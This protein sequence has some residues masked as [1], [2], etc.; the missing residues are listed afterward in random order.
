MES[1]EC[2]LID[3]LKD[4]SSALMPPFKMDGVQNEPYELDVPLQT[5]SYLHESAEKRNVCKKSHREEWPAKR[6]LTEIT[7]PSKQAVPGGNQLDRNGDIEM[8]EPNK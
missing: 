4:A 2:D 7:Q 6:G 1:V 5:G 8:V 3:P